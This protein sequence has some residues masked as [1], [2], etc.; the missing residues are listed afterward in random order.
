MND[1]S[2]A[3]KIYDKTNQHIGYIKELA[4]DIWLPIDANKE[5]I[6]SPSNKDDAKA[7]V[8]SNAIKPIQP[9]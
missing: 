7:I 6:S 5:T 9:S 8:I 1:V 3:E 4:E 2:A